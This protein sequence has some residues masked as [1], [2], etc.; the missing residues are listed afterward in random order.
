M[1]TSP[2]AVTQFEDSL[3]V[4]AKPWT[5]LADDAVVSELMAGFFQWDEPFVLAFVDQKSFLEDMRQCSPETARYCSPLLVNAIC[6]LRSVRNWK[7]H[8]HPTEAWKIFQL[9]LLGEAHLKTRQGLWTRKR[10]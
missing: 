8:D 1:Q 9:T 10:A 2:D 5:D 7:Q 6:A 4:S 3:N